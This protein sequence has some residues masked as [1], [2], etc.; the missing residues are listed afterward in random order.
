LGVS[1]IA[2]GGVAQFSQLMNVS[3]TTTSVLPNRFGPG[4]IKEFYGSPQGAA[5]IGGSNPASG[6]KALMEFER[7][8]SDIPSTATSSIAWNN[9]QDTL[10]ISPSVKATVEVPQPSESS[11]SNNKPIVVEFERQ[12]G[13]VIATKIHGS[14]SMQQLKQQLCLFYQAYNYRVMYPHIVFTTLPLSLEEIADL[15]QQVHPANLTVVVDNPGLPAMLQNMTMQQQ[16]VLFEQCGQRSI[17]KFTWMTKCK[18]DNARK[19]DPLSY[20]WQAEFR[21]LHLWSRPEL[22]EYR[23]M[24]WL[25]SDAFCGKRWERDPVAYMIQEQ[26]AIFFAHFPMG[27]SFGSDW[28]KRIQAA[29]GY[30]PCRIKLYEGHLHAQN[31]SSD[32]QKPEFPQVHGFFHIT[33]LNFYRSPQVM[34][35]FR[36]MVGDTKFSRRYD[37]QIGVTVPAA[38]LAPNRSFEMGYRG[39]D[40]YV[41]HNGR[42]DGKHWATSKNFATGYWIQNAT[43]NFPEAV[44]KCVVNNHGR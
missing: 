14:R 5:N 25:D 8:D 3:S 37:D 4:S 43:T 42:L 2:V 12:E 7:D 44:D 21:A 28:P 33:D 41:Y 34:N 27:R 18:E 35:W 9:D 20:T 36:I 13:V 29:F 23:Y 17:E 30:S 38:I 39:F 24:L 1:I 19:T 16:Q 15:Q 31:T 6:E 32:C 10:N 11:S 26:M 22:A 40:M